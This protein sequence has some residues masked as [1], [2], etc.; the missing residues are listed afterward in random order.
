MKP[1]NYKAPSAKALISSLNISPE[2]AATV[3]GLIRGE[4][5]TKDAER[6]PKSNAYFAKCYHEPHRLTRI[7]ECL[8][9]CLETFGVECIGEVRTYGPPAEY[10]NTGDTYAATLVFD[11]IAGN[12]KL[13]SWGDWLEKNENKAAFK[14]W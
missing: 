4:I 11:H 5:R 7:L 2:Q 8:N 13:T 6:F 9:E 10:L 1:T 3:R 12:F 14:N